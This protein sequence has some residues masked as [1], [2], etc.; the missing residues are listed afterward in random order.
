MEPMSCSS[1][2]RAGALRKL[3]A[4]GLCL[5]LVAPAARAADPEDLAKIGLA[6]AFIGGLLAA[7]SKGPMQVKI[8]ASGITNQPPLGSQSSARHGEP[9]FA[10]FR[11]ED[12][13]SIRFG[14]DDRMAVEMMEPGTY[15][16]LS[17][18]T[19]FEDKEGD[20]VLNRNLA[21]G[22]GVSLDYKEEMVR[23]TS[24]ASGFRY[25]LVYQG[26]AAGVL[27]LLYREYVDDL[28][29]PAFSQELVYDLSGGFPLEIVFKELDITVLDAGNR[30][31]SYIVNSDRPSWLA[32][33][34]SP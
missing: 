25:E 8:Y 34:S 4:A 33:S 5:F 15:C 9:V 30:A 29:R 14:H 10:I 1:S 24:R 2:G 6:G 18:G 11:Y 20:G 22:R 31:F 19:C 12:V 3:V 17:S 28:S 7:L 21:T 16:D 32:A 23:V 13:N 26:A 27:H